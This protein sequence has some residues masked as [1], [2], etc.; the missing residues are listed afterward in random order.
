MSICDSKSLPASCRV[1]EPCHWLGWAVR[2]WETGSS[3]G[4][5]PE[6]VPAGYGAIRG[7][8]ADIGRPGIGAARARRGHT[9]AMR[10]PVCGMDVDKES[11]AAAIEET[12]QAFYFCSRAYADRFVKDPS[13]YSRSS[14]SA[15]VSPTPTACWPLPSFGITRSHPYGLS[16]TPNGPACPLTGCPLNRSP[17]GLHVLRPIPFCL[18]AVAN[19]PADP[20]KLVAR[21][22]VILHR[23]RPSLRFSAGRLLHHP[24]RG[25]HSVHFRYG[26]HARQVAKATL[27]TRGSDGFPGGPILRPHQRPFTAH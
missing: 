10:D 25:L 6:T 19:T 11:A 2:R 4:L 7:N 9:G 24:F 13:S 27:Y 15:P 14:R 23:R 21:S 22:L 12:G 16:A 3:S 1:H 26:L 17:L 18:H 5:S 20:M 8:I